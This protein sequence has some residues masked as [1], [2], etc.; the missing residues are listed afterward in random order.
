M[1]PP[2]SSRQMLFVT[3]RAALFLFGILWLFLCACILCVVVR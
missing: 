2:M 1:K 3:V